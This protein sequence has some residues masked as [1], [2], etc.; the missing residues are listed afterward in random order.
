MNQ[1][2]PLAAAPRRRALSAVRLRLGHLY[3]QLAGRLLVCAAKAFLRAGEGHEVEHCRAAL[4]AGNCENG[5]CGLGA[6]ERLIGPLE[7]IAHFAPGRA[8]VV[9]TRAL[10]DAGVWSPT[11]EQAP[12]PHPIEHWLCCGCAHI[13]VHDEPRPDALAGALLAGTRTIVRAPTRKS[14]E[15]ADPAV[16]APRAA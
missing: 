15:S 8:G 10:I 9:A 12:R 2:Y 7:T 14:A 3:G 5:H 16:A 6:A 11:V 4:A 13:P 1:L